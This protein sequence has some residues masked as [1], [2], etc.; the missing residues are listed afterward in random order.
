MFYFSFAT[1]QIAVDGKYL[2]NQYILSF[3]G[4]APM[5]DPQVVVYFALVNPKNTIQYG[6]FT[7]GPMIKEAMISC[8]SI[9]GIPPQTNGI[10]LDARYWIDKKS[11]LVENYIGLNRNSIY[12]NYKYHIEFEGTGNKVIAQLPEVGSSIVEGGTVILY[13]GD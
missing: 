4:I 8:F 7:V 6:G 13:L 12:E 3:I 10:P 9:L 5:N 1:A 2:E 11:Y